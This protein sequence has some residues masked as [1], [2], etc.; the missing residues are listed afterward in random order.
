MTPCTCMFERCG[1]REHC[2]AAYTAAAGGWWTACRALR[3]HMAVRLR[4]AAARC[5]GAGLAAAE[6]MHAMHV[7]CNM[8]VVVQCCRI[9]K[10]DL[11]GKLQGLQRLDCCSARGVVGTFQRLHVQIGNNKTGSHRAGHTAMQIEHRELGTS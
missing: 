9:A 4:A 6:A 5:C 2:P 7:K 3:F 1:W 8:V 11:H 10:G